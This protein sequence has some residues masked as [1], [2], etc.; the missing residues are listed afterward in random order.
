MQEGAET[1]PALVLKM[2]KRDAKKLA[3]EVARVSALSIE[4]ESAGIAVLAWEGPS[5]LGVL[6]RGPFSR[7]DFGQWE[8]E[9]G[10]LMISA[11]GTKRLSLR[12]E[13]VLFQAEVKLL[14][15]GNAPEGLYAADALDGASWEGPPESWPKAST[16][17]LAFAEPLGIWEMNADEVEQAVTIAALVWSVVVIADEVGN[18]SPLRELRSQFAGT[19]DENPLEFLIDRKRRHFPQDRRILAIREF[20]HGGARVDV[21]VMWRMP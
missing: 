16:V 14:E 18:D 6:T 12:D 3:A 11:G 1:K 13:D 10:L 4:E 15:A 17:L 5:C 20:T 9:G 2:A 21:D 19:G 7:A 8:K